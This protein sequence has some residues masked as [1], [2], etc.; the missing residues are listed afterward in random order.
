MPMALSAPSLFLKAMFKSDRGKEEFYLHFSMMYRILKISCPNN[1]DANITS[2]CHYSFGSHCSN[3]LVR[4]G[5]A[6]ISTSTMSLEHREKSFKYF[7]KYMVLTFL[8]CQDFE[9]LAWKPGTHGAT[10]MLLLRKYKQKNTSELSNK[11]GELRDEEII[12]LH[13]V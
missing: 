1:T 10:I 4:I 6:E 2:C 9:Y 8:R 12:T 7:M 13:S 3:C 5:P 11:Q